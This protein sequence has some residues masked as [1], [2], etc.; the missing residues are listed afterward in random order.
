LVF[1]LESD[2]PIVPNLEF[3]AIGIFVL[4]VMSCFH[5]DFIPGCGRSAGWLLGGVRELL[6]GGVAVVAVAWGV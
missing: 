1:Q 5:M 6:M 4:H 3:G 2:F